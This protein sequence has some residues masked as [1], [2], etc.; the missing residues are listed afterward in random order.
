MDKATSCGL[1]N[2]RPR[3]LQRFSSAP[4]YYVGLHFIA[5]VLQ[6][7]VF[8]YLSSVLST[9]EKRFGLKSKEAAWLYSGNEIAQVCFIFFLP[10]VGRVKKRPLFVGLSILVAAIGC[11]I[12]ALPHFTS[13]YQGKHSGLINDQGCQ[14]RSIACNVND[15]ESSS[16]KDILSLIVIFIGIFLF[17]IS[18]SFYFS[19]GIPYADDNTNR[20]NSPFMLSIIM[21]SRLVGPTLG[22]LL[23]AACLS[24][25]Q[26]P[27]QT[28][29]GLDE[30][31]PGWIGAWWLGFVVVGVLSLIV[32]PFF[33]LFPRRLNVK[34]TDAEI[35]EQKMKEEKE[36]KITFKIFFTDLYLVAKRLITN[37]VWLLNILSGVFFLFGFLGIATFFP[38]YFE[39]QFRRRASS[40]S[41]ISGMFKTI[42]AVLGTVL[43]GWLIS[44]YKFGAKKMAAYC[45]LTS[46]ITAVG[47]LIFMLVSCPS[48]K[49]EALNSSCAEEC[50]CQGIGYN[51]VCATGDEATLYF[52]PCHAGC[53]PND[54]TS[55][56]QKRGNNKKLYQ[57]CKCSVGIDAREEKSPSNWFNLLN[58]TKA[59]AGGKV[60]EGY[61]P[62]SS[63]KGA[64]YAI[65][66]VLGICSLMLATSRIPNMLLSLRVLSKED[67]A[68]SFTLSVSFLSLLAF[69]PGPIVFG[70]LFD[71]SCVIWSK[72]CD[73]STANCLV[74][75]SYS[76]RTGLGGLAL[77]CMLLT[78]L[79]DFGVWWFVPAD[80]DIYG[81]ESSKASD[82]G[83]DTLN[84]DGMVEI[85]LKER[86][87]N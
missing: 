85:E 46:L 40:A 13:T 73:G 33:T 37:K 77:V 50:H 67:K 29:E 49:V 80:L 62:E 53:D 16:A 61:C 19:F 47:F 72:N 82:S 28:P 75:D 15:D 76:M 32:G 52:S 41:G 4:G 39:Y 22:Y 25:Y 70:S 48:L 18:I 8:T 57:N 56:P 3:W 6:S 55:I 86:E 59:E 58:I 69:L 21:S 14:E 66:G 42:P 51:P 60:L 11:F 31:H 26:R 68:A 9:I 81:E 24:A 1:F 45:V 36:E 54:I 83:V 35:I 2:F 78:A 43:S 7:I 17:G 64:F 34:N 38:K 87:E 71:N 23:G 79:C 65:L 10:F 5:G 27:G 74:Y 84:D 12:M 30:D 63:C 44:R 20:T